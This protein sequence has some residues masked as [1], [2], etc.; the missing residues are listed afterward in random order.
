[1]VSEICSIPTLTFFVFAGSVG[2]A[3]VDRPTAA[4]YDESEYSGEG[5]SQQEMPWMHLSNKQTYRAVAA[6]IPINIPAIH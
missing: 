6:S 2:Y 5:E 3:T 1:M 4:G